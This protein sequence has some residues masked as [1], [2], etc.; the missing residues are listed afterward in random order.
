[1]TGSLGKLVGEGRFD[2]MFDRQ[3]T[4]ALFCM[5]ASFVNALLHFL[6]NNLAVRMRGLL[7][8]LLHSKYMK[9]ML[10]YKITHSSES[11]EKTSDVVQKMTEDLREFS[12][13]FSELF[14]KILR[15]IAEIYFVSKSLGGLMGW[16]QLAAFYGFFFIA[17]FWVKFVSPPFAWFHKTA[18]KLEGELRHH[19]SRIAT[20]SEQIA[21]YSNFFFFFDFCSLIFIFPKQKEGG[22]R[23]EE[24]LK[25]SWQKIE[26]L[27]NRHHVLHFIMSTY[28]GYVVKYGGTMF[29]YSMLIPAV[30]F[31]RHG[32]DKKNTA[33]TMQYY[34][35]STQ[36]FISLAGA[37]KHLL[38]SY[39]EILAMAGMA[40][41]VNQLFSTLKDAKKELEKEKGKTMQK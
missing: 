6:K 31:G 25:E 19:H 38:L 30:Y 22:K 16:E 18:H 37:C 13:L 11:Q 5:P 26:K 21:F 9:E 40:E 2:R 28:D 3:V 15:P 4:F 27:E 23:E 34:L 35:T 14:M 33:Q 7:T 1:M 24:I 36:L 20:S 29:A 32:I 17:G 10:F 8:K 41:R 12:E 39:K